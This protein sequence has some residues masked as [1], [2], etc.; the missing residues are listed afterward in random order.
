M[1]APQAGGHFTG[2]K[3]SE[4]H[5]K[6]SLLVQLEAQDYNEDSCF[7]WRR[8]KYKIQ[9]VFFSILIFSYIKHAVGSI[10]ALH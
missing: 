4:I 7:K 9:Q 5:W 2:R 8:S 6:V 10:F 1:Q 3:N